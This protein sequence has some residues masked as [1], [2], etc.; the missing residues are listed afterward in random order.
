MR[1]LITNPPWSNGHKTLNAGVKNRTPQIGGPDP[2]YKT[3]PF[4][5]AYTAAI[6]QRNGHEVFMIDSLAENMN[7]NKF[8][9]RI[10]RIQPDVVLIETSTPTI[11]SDLKIA[12]KIKEIISTKIIFSGTHATV[13]P[14]KNLE[15]NYVDIVLRGEYEFSMLDVVN[16]LANGDNLAKIKGI[17]YRK[18]RKIIITP[19]RELSNLDSLPY[20]ARD[21][22]PLKNYYD[23]IVGRP[24]I[25][26]TTMRGCPF[27]CGF[28]LWTHV[29][30]KN[31]FRVRNTLKVIEEIE[32]IKKKYSPRYI[33]FDDDVFTFGKERVIKLCDELLERG[34]NIEWGAMTRPDLLDEELMTKMH[35]AGCVALKIGVETAIPSI[36][37]KIPK[38]ISIDKI[39]NVFQSAK[40]IGIKTQA[41]YVFGLPG[42]TKATIKKTIRFALNLSDKAQFLLL[43]PYPGTPYYEMYK[44]NGWLINPEKWD[45]FH[46]YTSS[47][48]L[49]T[50]D[51][52]ELKELQREAYRE[53]YT[54]KVKLDAF[55]YSLRKDGIKRTCMRS[56]FWLLTKCKIIKDPVL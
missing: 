54:R 35:D 24:Q 34:I 48:K 1:I 40:K 55:I 51:P 9:K 12:K 4:F 19:E 42:D 33:Y 22:L 20:P 17:A 41:L 36:M 6:L 18:G 27:N 13:F 50:L 11:D 15:K 29:M 49:P 45:I 43:T 25:Q 37:K 39:K 53:F 46:P 56:I 21:L 47:I 38:C 44:K 28:C 23:G 8:L 52:N 30:F 10:E 14:E 31:K 32:F 2:Y 7:E 5:M 26:M 16:C 3:F